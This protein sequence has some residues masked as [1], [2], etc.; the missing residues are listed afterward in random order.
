MDRWSRLA[1]S[2]RHAAEI[3]SGY[4]A[5]IPIS[6]WRFLATLR[7]ASRRAVSRLT[8]VDRLP[9]RT[10]VLVMGSRYSILSARNREAIQRARPGSRLEIVNAMRHLP[11]LEAPCGFVSTRGTVA[12]SIRGAGAP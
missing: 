9:A 4:A 2:G 12:A 11:Q 3:C 10:L 1:T 7:L 5:E 8:P 6:A